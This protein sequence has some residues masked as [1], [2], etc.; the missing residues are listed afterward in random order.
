MTKVA[1]F[2]KV[3]FA[4]FAKDYLG[5]FGGTRR[6]MISLQL[7]T[8]DDLTEHVRTIYDN[9]KLPERISSRSPIYQFFMPFD[10]VYSEGGQSIPSG[11]RSKIDD[12]WVLMLFSPDHPDVKYRSMVDKTIDVI[13][14]DYY[15]H[16]ISN[17]HILIRIPNPSIPSIPRLYHTCHVGDVLAQGI[18]IP[19]G[20]AD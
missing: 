11:I 14:S 3:P 6:C 18:F 19:V 1:Q 16:S 8:A 5:T 2:E 4:Q 17:G 15:N 9:I 7:E 13:D 10:I 20:I 12:G